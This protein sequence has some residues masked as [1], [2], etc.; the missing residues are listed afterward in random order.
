MPAAKITTNGLAAMAFSVALLWGCV[1]GERVTV[2]R[3][4]QQCAR[5]LHDIRLLKQRNRSLPV[6]TPAPQLP[7][8]VRPVAG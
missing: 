5:A 2:R 3:A 6:H 4:Q 8:P 7:R 1:V